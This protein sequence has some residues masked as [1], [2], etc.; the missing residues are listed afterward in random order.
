MDKLK[1]KKLNEM[2][3][4]PTRGSEYSCGLDIYSVEEKILKSG[5]RVAIHTG[6]AVEIPEFHYGRI[7]PRS[8]LALKH[9]IDVLAGVIDSDYRG[10]IMCL[11]INF[12]QED[13]IIKIGDRIAQLIVEKISIIEPEWD[14]FLNSSERNTDGFGST[15]T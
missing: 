12:G 5:E 2:A 11:I 15:G 4:L 1:F 8:G 6:L 14:E 13:F 9:G 10:E 7:A 3:Y